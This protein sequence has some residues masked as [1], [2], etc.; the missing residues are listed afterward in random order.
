MFD[1]GESRDEMGNLNAA[2]EQ[3]EF[4]IIASGVEYGNISSSSIGTQMDNDEDHDDQPQPHDRPSRPRQSSEISSS[5]GTILA[6]QRSSRTVHLDLSQLDPEEFPAILNR[7][8]IHPFRSESPSHMYQEH[9]PPQRSTPETT[10]RPET[11]PYASPDSSTVSLPTSSYISISSL[12]RGSSPFAG[13]SSS[14]PAR[15]SGDSPASHPRDRTHPLQFG[16]R[17]SY[18]GRY[19]QSE[20]GPSVYGHVKREGHD[21]SLVLPL[22]ALPGS[23]IRD[24]SRTPSPTWGSHNARE[25]RNRTRGPLDIILT[26]PKAGVDDFVRH[27]DEVEGIRLFRI[28]NGGS[29]GKQAGERERRAIAVIQMGPGADEGRTDG[30]DEGVVDGKNGKL[31]ARL[32]LMMDREER[33]LEQVSLPSRAMPSLV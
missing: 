23:M 18:P 21:I 2:A 25:A 28:E 17:P 14:T 10:S 15:E 24:R 3:R 32:H 13:S 29:A 5:S 16:A 8:N 1:Q 20:Q 7:S 12:S 22:I 26:G 19:D 30:G 33:N 27:L 4:E 6:G 9:S 11:Y 31:L